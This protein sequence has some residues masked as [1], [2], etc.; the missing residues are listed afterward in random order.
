MHI[1]LIRNQVAQ[2]AAQL[3]HDH[4]I[5]DFA[6]AKRKA[7]KQLGIAD[8]HHL[9]S[10]PEITLALQNYLE[11]FHADNHPALL[12]EFTALAID[13]MQ[14]LRAFNPYITGAVLNGTV[15]ENSDIQ[16]ELFT[17]NEKEVELYL[18]NNHIQFKQDQRQIKHKGNN[19]HIP[20]FII[21]TEI[22]DIYI[23]VHSPSQ[24]RN[25]PR[26][27]PKEA[28]KRASLNYFLNLQDFN[29]EATSSAK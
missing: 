28:L 11:L 10:N 21:S 15:T 9:P 13:T 29:H 17:D 23:S 12:A 24:I 8:A 6:L 18:L 27:I 16:I 26:D 1:D 5:K 14:M 7:A 4:G 25:T 22:C 19:K 3:I 20:C 2:L